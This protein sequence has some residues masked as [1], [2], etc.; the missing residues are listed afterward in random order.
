M[1]T[2]TIVIGSL[3]QA[4]WEQYRKVISSLIPEYQV[5]FEIISS[6]RP[7]RLVLVDCCEHPLTKDANDVTVLSDNVNSIPAGW[8][9]FS[10]SVDLCLLAKW[11]AMAVSIKL[12]NGFSF[13]FSLHLTPLKDHFLDIVLHRLQQKSSP[14]PPFM[15]TDDDSWHF[16]GKVVEEVS[17]AKGTNS[18]PILVEGNTIFLLEAGEEWNFQI[19]GGVNAMIFCDDEGKILFNLSVP[20][21]AAPSVLN[22]LHAQ[23]ISL[24]PP[25]PVILNDP[26]FPRLNQ[27]AKHNSPA[28]L[29]KFA[30]CARLNDPNYLAGV[31]YPLLRA[32]FYQ[33][34]CRDLA[35]LIG[36][37]ASYLL[38][39]KPALTNAVSVKRPRLEE[40][41]LVVHEFKP[42]VPYLEC[43]LLPP[44]IDA[45]DPLLKQP[46]V[47]ILDKCRLI[48]RLG[49]VAKLRE[50]KQ[51]FI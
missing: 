29:A 36:P 33:Q 1:I 41:G 9:L 16:T 51:S 44:T 42:L 38:S 10:R 11:H 43:T 7:F 23:G 17:A 39:I 6:D 22:W 27:L 50:E 5:S 2:K 40:D 28:E 45:Q 21:P 19:E 35:R 48:T 37:E 25:Q 18:I 26:R 15:L 4:E 13:A 31:E 49:H 24:L 8:T 3:V 34:A 20:N 30:E 12:D 46:R 14:Y 32:R 47:S